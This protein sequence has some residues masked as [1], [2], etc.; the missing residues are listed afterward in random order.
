M[1]IGKYFNLSYEVITQKLGIEPKRFVYVALGDSTTEG[2][3]ASI[4]EKSFAQIIFLSIKEHRK[5]AE[6][7]NL[8]KQESRISEVLNYQ[9]NKAIALK[10]HLVTLSIGAN[11]LKY[12]TR[13]K[14][15]EKDLHTVL[16]RLKHE[17]YA[18]VVINTI[19]DVSSAPRIPNKLKKVTNILV[20]RF[21][22][23]ITEKALEIG[24][25]LV[26]FYTQSR[27]FAK[28]YPVTLFSTDGYHPSDIGY[29]LWANTII[30]HLHHVI[31]ARQK[32]LG[33][34]K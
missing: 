31:F 16:F 15:F 17:T 26:D 11:D 13:L 1:N 21:N 4:P 25:D 12:N 27:I 34:M 3:G 22:R 30:T 10:P 28:V 33:L 23:I 19:P 7:H 9:L 18:T 20:R 24:V 8:G 2:I 29:A 32:F 5:Y 14:S 6:F